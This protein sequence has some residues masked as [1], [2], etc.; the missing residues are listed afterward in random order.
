MKKEGKPN[1]IILDKDFEVAVHMLTEKDLSRQIT[2]AHNLL[3]KVYFKH[4]GLTNKNVWKSVIE[5][6]NDILDRAFPNWPISKYPIQP[7]KVKV[8][9]FKFVKLCLNNFNYILKYAFTLCNEYQKRYNKKHIKYQIFYW[10]SNNLPKLSFSN[11][12]IPEYPILTIPIRFRKKDYTTTAR[13]YYISI[14]ED[15][16]EEYKKVDIPDFFNIKDYS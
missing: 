3:L 10:I 12:Y 7:P 8:N 9:E 4:Y 14:V 6:H 5:T 11:T 16:M 13:R 2:N 15:P 1:L